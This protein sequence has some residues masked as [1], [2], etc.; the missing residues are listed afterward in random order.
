M[1]DGFYIFYVGKRL[2]Y[3]NQL[4]TVRYIGEVKGTKGEWLGVE[5]D[6]PTRGKHSGEHGGT[7]YFE[8]L[9]QS[10]ATS[11]SFIRP[12]RKY[13]PFRSFAEALKAKYASDPVQD[14][15]IHIVFA[16]KPGDNALKKDPLARINQPIRISGKEV[17]E[18]GFDKIRKQLAQL[19]ELKIVI[20][21]GLRMDRSVARLREGMEEWEKGL[22][23][24]REACPKAIELDL[25]RNL[26]EEWRE[27]ASICEQLE[28]LKS[29]RVEYA[30]P[31]FPF[32]IPHKLTPP[33]GNRFRDISIT[34]AERP[35]CLAA[36]ANITDL[37]LEDTLLPWESIA[38]LT[39]LFPALITFSASSNYYTS[40]TSH[41]LNPAITSLT[42]EDNNLTS[43]SVI[44]SLASLPSLRRLILKSNKI[45]IITADSSPSPPVFSSSVTELDLTYNDI[46][47]WSFLDALPRSF[48]GLTSLRISHNPLYAHLQTPDGRPMTPE[49]GYMLTIARLSCLRTLNYSPIT[50]KERLNAE[51]YYLSLIA[52][53]LAYAPEKDAPAILES[54]P[55]YKELC[56]E[57]GE[58][59]I[60]RE[61]GGVNPNSLAARLVRLHVYLK[62]ST[63]NQQVELEI[64][65]R[66]TAYTL[67]GMVSREFKTKPMGM[68][69]VWET[70]DWMPAPKGVEEEDND[71]ES[72]DEE[73]S[74]VGRVMR[75]VEIVPGTRSVGTWI[76]G[77]EAT[78]RVEL[79]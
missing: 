5:W 13:D 47:T 35:R 26:F 79:R 44:S 73:E 3:D 67:I 12:A 37:K 63:E 45:S 68:R 28:K 60:A 56:E 38:S 75:E 36:F 43:L 11:A 59:V 18:V 31:S 50:D 70:G 29:L 2:S 1:P 9:N 46:S 10:T 20:L 64:P 39:H 8:C 66:C 77:M 49:D 14:P 27:I 71:S 48:P 24:V 58:P 72:E 16:T 76:D 40:L 22:T 25:S 53:E 4:C 23:D 17:E 69:L 54:H 32:I 78:I 33:S 19:S 62:D 15:S 61:R 51:S 55:R 52:K 7:K 34:A 21:D 65:G 41:I 30:M 74:E 6:D 42:L 57:Y